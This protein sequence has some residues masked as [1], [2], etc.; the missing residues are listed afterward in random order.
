MNDLHVRFIKEKNYLFGEEISASLS[1]LDIEINDSI[2]GCSIYILNSDETECFLKF[3]RINLDVAGLYANEIEYILQKTQLHP[4]L[5]LFV[6]EVSKYC[7][8]ANELIGTSGNILLLRSA[9]E[10]TREP[11]Y[12]SLIENILNE[13]FVNGCI[14]AIREEEFLNNKGYDKFHSFMLKKLN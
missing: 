8:D 10:L 12:L 4:V 2:D 1:D 7:V 5:S 9:S 13:E 14:L 11:K 3:Y 6:H